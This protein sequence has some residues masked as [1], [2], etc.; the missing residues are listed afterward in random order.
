[1]ND[2]NECIKL[3]DKSINKLDLAC[4]LITEMLYHQNT[5]TAQFCMQMLDEVKPIISELRTANSNI[6]KEPSVKETHL[7]YK[8]INDLFKDIENK[9]ESL[10]ANKK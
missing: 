5:D 1:M 10:A 6:S 3:I 2:T 9:I 4:V 7:L 8:K